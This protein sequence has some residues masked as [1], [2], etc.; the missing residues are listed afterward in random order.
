MRL[1]VVTSLED[2]LAGLFWEAYVRGGGPVPAAVFFLTSRRRTPLWRRL[3][4]GVLLFGI[5]GAV[6]WWL[7]GRRARRAPERIFGGAATFHH[8]HTVNRGD[9]HDALRDANP[10]LLVSVGSPVIL[11]PDVLRLA[12]IGAVNV[13]NGK[14]P[15]YRGLFGTF[16]EAYRG[17]TWGHISIHTMLEDVDTGPV[18]AHAAVLLDGRS[19]LAALV[20]KKRLGG[21]LLAW[22]VRFAEREG[23]LPSPPA[24]ALPEGGGPAGYYSWPSLKEIAGLALRRRVRR[25]RSI[26]GAAA[27]PESPPSAAGSGGSERNGPARP[28]RLAHVTTIDLSL[29]FLLRDQLRAF[30]EHG[31][32][33][34]GISAPGPWV[35]ELARDGV[36]HIA[37][38]ALQRRWNPAADLRALIG[39]VRALRRIR[40]VIVHTHTPKA[41]VLGGVAA[42]L[43]R[44]PI[45]VNTFH[46]LYGM[47]GSRLR[48]SLF[49]MIERIAARCSDFEFSQSRED[50]LALRRLGIATIDASAYLGNGVDLQA[51]D[52]DRVDRDA[53]RARLGIPH[54]AVVLGTV[55]RLVWEKG[56]VEFFAM[57]EALKKS[58]PSVEVVAVGPQE[59][60]KEDGVPAAVIDDLR[61]RGVVRF[62]GMRV[63]MPEL[64]AAMDVFVLPSY[65]EGFPRA[66]IEAAAMGRPIVATDI[67]GC[68]EV[69]HDGVNGYLVPL[70]DAGRLLDRVRRLV[71]DGELRA[72]LGAESRAR[73]LT[74]FDERRVIGRTLDVYQRLL[75]EKKRDVRI[76]S[77]QE[78]PARG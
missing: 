37:V 27:P 36:A 45:V 30:Q 43:A 44:V 19:L 17:E 10:D 38:P 28:V 7:L 11:K 62:L 9:G 68:R 59:P 31:F 41:R 32:E 64:Y 18:L 57:A 8:V 14:L 50:L 35:G 65:R 66:A 61:R 55:G 15:A 73:A 29:R 48:R 1:V 47:D 12:R 75:K 40:P 23:V 42:R 25:S 22:L 67:R 26:G 39:L 16:W 5:T 24:D 53:V 54:G 20:D 52:P 46:G 58:H 60:G 63:D 33:T 21:S 4:E 13:H 3:T 49:A 74:E 76:G 56:Y 51:F 70:R 77:H 34:I 71:A 72:R 2:P 69:V 78:S 6:R